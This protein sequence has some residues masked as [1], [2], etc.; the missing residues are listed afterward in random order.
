MPWIIVNGGKTYVI[1]TND[2]LGGTIQLLIYDNNKNYQPERDV[3]FFSDY[4][5]PFTFTVPDG[6]G[7]IRFH[8]N[9]A[10]F[11]GSSDVF[12]NLREIKRF[13]FCANTL[14]ISNTKITDVNFLCTTDVYQ[15]KLPDTVNNFICDSAYDLDTDYLPDGDFDMVHHEQIEA[16]T[17][18]YG[19]NVTKGVETEIRNEPF[20][21]GYYIDE[22]GDKITNSY[23]TTSEVLYVK[24]GTTVHFKSDTMGYSGSNGI[25]AIQY[26]DSDEILKIDYYTGSWADYSR[27]GATILLEPNTSRFRITVLTSTHA[28]NT[29]TDTPITY[30]LYQKAY[31][32]NLIPSAADGSLIFSMYAPNTNVAVPA[33]GIWDLYGLTF[34]EFYTYGMNNDIVV[35]DG[36]ITMPHRYADY[37]VTIQNANIKPTNHPTMLYPLLVNENKP[38]VGTIDYSDY[39]GEDLSYAMAYANKSEV[40]ISIPNDV[41]LNTQY[42]Y[43]V[44]KESEYEYNDPR[45]IAKYICNAKGVVPTFNSGYVAYKVNERDNGDGTYTTSIIAD[46]ISNLPTT[47]NFKGIKQLQKVYYLNTSAVTDMS[48]MFNG[49]SNL[50]YINA[51]NLVHS[52][53]TTLAYL[54]ITCTNLESIDV[55]SWDTS[56][57]TNMDRI[58]ASCF[59]LSSIVGV[60]NWDVSKVKNFNLA[61]SH[62]S[63]ESLG[64]SSWITSS[65]T[66]MASMFTNCSKLTSLDVSNWDTSSVTDMGGM[67]QGC[68]RLTSLDLSGWDT[69]SLGIIN[70][71]FRDCQSLTYLDLSSWDTSRITQ[72]TQAIDRCGALKTLKWNNWKPSIALTSVGLSRESTKDIVSK[73][74]TV[75]ES[76]TLNLSSNLLSYLSEEEIALANSKGWTLA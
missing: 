14:D 1:G 36:N 21:V 73:L 9:D 39:Q 29:F 51:D 35:T 26:N 4:S 34:E 3:T 65:A 57:V 6:C 62:T 30:I 66:S 31:A 71:M 5:L 56:N 55:S 22:N 23:S 27:N 18:N 19:R 58:F 50:T 28:G 47:I 60:D 69:S 32:P 64:V 8:I 67:F 7:F 61:F 38:I 68:S 76:R 41:A 53:V 46:D 33:E 45:T 42:F 37:N 11:T 63:I 70:Y 72:T 17:T 40:D 54:F 13:A 10:V 2:P 44:D 16:Y 24:G 20:E 74:A 48:F 25:R 75:T 43:N 52:G 59:K 15:L 49:C 12:L